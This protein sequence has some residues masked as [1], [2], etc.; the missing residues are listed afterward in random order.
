MA[1]VTE[2]LHNHLSLWK[3]N[4]ANKVHTSGISTQAFTT[5]S[6]YFRYVWVTQAAPVR[7]QTTH[8]SGA[9]ANHT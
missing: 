2:T 7:G 9:I 4:R 5:T 8:I 3:K 1:D 6:L